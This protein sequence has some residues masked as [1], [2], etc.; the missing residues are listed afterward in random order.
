MPTTPAT[1]SQVP[2]V[3]YME[4]GTTHAIP[5]SLVILE[6]LEDFAPRAPPL[7]PPHPATRAAAR[8]AA[9]RLDERFVPPFYRLLMG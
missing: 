5:E 7:L 9:R 6:F 1:L 8:L 3:L 2:T 4:D